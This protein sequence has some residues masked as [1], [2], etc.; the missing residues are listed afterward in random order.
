MS[1]K[2]PLS[3][4]E[5]G[6]ALDTQKVNADIENWQTSSALVGKGE[7]NFRDQGLDLC[8]FEAGSVSET[9]RYI[10][11]GAGVVLNDLTPATSCPLRIKAT[12]VDLGQGDYILRY[13]LRYRSLMNYGARTA[14]SGYTYQNSGFQ[15]YWIFRVYFVYRYD[16]ITYPLRRL[17]C[18]ERKVGLREMTLKAKYLDGSITFACNFRKTFLEM[19]GHNVPSDAVLESLEIYVLPTSVF[20]APIPQGEV[21]VQGFTMQLEHLKR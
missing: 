9:S 10:S 19:E 6:D 8:N 2:V 15:H 16:E 13:S 4:P 14:T 12:N 3:E 17:L 21:R 7:D 5:S 1:N 11:L 18:S 20:T